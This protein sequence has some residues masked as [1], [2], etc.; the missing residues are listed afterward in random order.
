MLISCGVCAMWQARQHLEDVVHAVA[1]HQRAVAMAGGGDVSYNELPN[2][3]PELE[4]RVE[5][6]VFAAFDQEDRLSKKAQQMCDT[7]DNASGGHGSSSDPTVGCFCMWMHPSPTPN[8]HRH[9]GWPVDCGCAVCSPW[10]TKPQRLQRLNKPAQSVL[11]WA[12]SNSAVA[13]TLVPFARGFV[14]CAT[15]SRRRTPPS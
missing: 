10:M 9:V 5:Q 3:L 6:L 7:P 15:P 11:S 8:S 13:Q 4:Q 1:S 2:T 14:K 12:A